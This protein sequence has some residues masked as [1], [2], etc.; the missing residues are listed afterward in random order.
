M[1]RFKRNRVEKAFTFKGTQKC[2]SYTQDSPKETPK[3]VRPKNI[4][5]LSSP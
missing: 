4:A 2:H 5:R 3:L 1:R